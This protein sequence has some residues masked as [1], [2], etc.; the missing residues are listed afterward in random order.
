MRYPEFLSEGETIGFVAPSFGCAT[1]PYKT[2]FG[3]ALDNFR[4]R[5]FKTELGP[6]CYEGKGIGISNTPKACGNE[7]NNM[8]A[9]S[10]NKALI[11]CGGGELM[12][13][14]LNHV[15]FNS[16]SKA[17]AKWYMGY[18]DNTNFTYLLNTICDTASIYAPCAASFGMK[19][20]HKALEDAFSCITGEG[21][22]EDENKVI[23]KEFKGYETFELESLKSEDNPAPPYNLTEKKVIRKYVGC[24]LADGT[25]LEFEGRLIGGCMD[26][27]VNLLGTDFD[28]TKQFIEKY[29]DD[30]IV[31]FIESCDLNVFSI[32]RAMWQMENAGWFKY[33][34]G[35][36]IGRPL[37]YGQEIMGLNQYDAVLGIIGKYNL[38][39]LMDCDFGHLSP[40]VPMI[41][42]AYVKVNAVDENMTVTYQL[43]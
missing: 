32:R 43:K 38:P 3:M 28:K 12:C 15:D 37:M 7:L 11:S 10:D 42:G 26:C 35:F 4:K 36:M 1:E 27:L 6:N 13:E 2:A 29:K 17:K 34:K 30:G 5:G 16:I 8:Y 18:S 31:W 39:I 41:G 33:V 25:S 21:F 14:I 23:S 20:W 19:E 40:A 22:F 24:D 9:S